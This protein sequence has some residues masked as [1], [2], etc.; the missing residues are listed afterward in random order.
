MTLPLRMSTS[1]TG[2]T[3]MESCF[4]LCSL[5]DIALGEAGNDGPGIWASSMHVG[6]HVLDFKLA[7]SWLPQI[8]VT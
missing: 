4:H 1:G 7:Q 2:V 6:D 3:N 5:P 8:F